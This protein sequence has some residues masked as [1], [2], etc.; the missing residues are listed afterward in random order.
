MGFRRLSRIA[1]FFSDQRA[2]LRRLPLAAG[3]GWFWTGFAPVA[4]LPDWVWNGVPCM[5][6]EDFIPVVAAV[7]VQPGDGCLPCGAQFE[8]PRAGTAPSALRRAVLP[9]ARHVSSRR[10]TRWD[11]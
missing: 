7:R 2:V 11:P 10:A 9:A 6:L 1:P 8:R 3:F 4:A 5:V